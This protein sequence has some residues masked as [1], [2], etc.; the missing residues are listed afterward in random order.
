MKIL[1]CGKEMCTFSKQYIPCRMTK[2]IGISFPSMRKSIK[3]VVAMKNLSS[4]AYIFTDRVEDIQIV[5][6][7]LWPL[8][9]LIPLCGFVSHRMQSSRD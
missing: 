1:K 2:L 9:A 6:L 3:H 5:V 4:S 7:M 8:A